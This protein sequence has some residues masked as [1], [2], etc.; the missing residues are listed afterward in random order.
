MRNNLCL[1]NIFLVASL[2]F[3]ALS[4]PVIRIS[5]AGNH[6]T[7]VTSDERPTWMDLKPSTGAS[8][9]VVESIQIAIN[10][11]HILVLKVQDVIIDNRGAI[12]IYLPS[13]VL[14]RE[15]KDYFENSENNLNIL[16]NLSSIGSV[17]RADADYPLSPPLRQV[18]GIKTA[19]E[20]MRNLQMEIQQRF[21]TKETLFGIYV[22]NSS[23]TESLWIT[24]NSHSGPITF[25]EALDKHLRRQKASTWNRYRILKP[26][27]PRLS[28]S[29]RVE[30]F[31]DQVLTL[32]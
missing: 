32:I 27:T 17:S 16:A 20:K 19:P 25:Y 8:S 29:R 28:F 31:C 9:F 6:V 3:N 5:E 1:L 15:V 26:I 2:H 11:P 23:A 7:N 10:R 22:L 21:R 24:E 12:I 14:A 30:W 18:S 13:E 4:A